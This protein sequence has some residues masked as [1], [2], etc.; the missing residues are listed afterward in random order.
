[1]GAH[2]CGWVL[3]GAGGTGGH[4]NKA[5]RGHL[6][7]N[8]SGFGSYDRGNFPGH[9]VLWFLPKMVKMGVDG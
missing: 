2:G 1:M 8:R 9:D 3:W 4:E 6:G 5:S 7:P